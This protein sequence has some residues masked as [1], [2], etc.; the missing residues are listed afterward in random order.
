VWIYVTANL[1]M[2]ILIVAVS[3]IHADRFKAGPQTI[4]WYGLCL[5]GVVVLIGALVWGPRRLAASGATS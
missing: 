5:A 4:I 1:L 2:L 3:V